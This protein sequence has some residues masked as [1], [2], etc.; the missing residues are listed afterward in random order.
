MLLVSAT[1]FSRCGDLESHCIPGACA[2]R[3]QDFLPSA[4][5]CS[6]VGLVEADVLPEHQYCRIFGFRLS[7]KQLVFSPPLFMFEESSKVF[8]LQCLEANSTFHT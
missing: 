6:T 7:A 3:S 4:V 2:G 1:H 5:T 8:L